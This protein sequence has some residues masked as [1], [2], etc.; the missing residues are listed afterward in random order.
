MNPFCSQ[1]ID[2]P[3][4]IRARDPDFIGERFRRNLRIVEAL[5][6]IAV[7]YGKTVTQLVINWTATYPGVTAPIVGVKRLS[8]VIENVGGV[9]WTITDEDRVRI[10][11]LLEGID[12]VP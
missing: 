5:K 1:P 12:I 9:G 11:R 10:A 2:R 7:G 4:G 8:Q 3:D 6:E